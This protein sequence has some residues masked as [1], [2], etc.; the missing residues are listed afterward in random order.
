M[1]LIAFL[2]LII[3]CLGLPRLRNFE[4]G[5]IFGISWAFQEMCMF[6][7]LILH[8]CLFLQQIDHDRTYLIKELLNC[9]QMENE[10]NQ[11]MFNR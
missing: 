6:L 11:V 9:A 5:I 4:R 2:I 1:C 3:K 7:K 10:D 8:V